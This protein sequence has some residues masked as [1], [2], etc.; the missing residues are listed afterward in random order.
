AAMAWPPAARDCD[1]VISP[2]VQ[3]RI[4]PMAWQGRASEGCTDSNR[5]STC[6]AHSAAHSARRRWS[7]SVSV[8]PR[9]MVMKRGS[10]SFGR[11][12]S[13]SCRLHS[14]WLVTL[15]RLRT[16]EV[17]CPERAPDRLALVV[18]G[19]WQGDLDHASGDALAGR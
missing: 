7:Q 2:R 19:V 6:S 1:M 9:R 10:R 11:I 17:L 18:P 15:D 14:G 16:V 4:C 5:C 13:F 8:P 12:T 3:A